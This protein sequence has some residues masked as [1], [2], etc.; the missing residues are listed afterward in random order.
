MLGRTY[1]II[2]LLVILGYAKAFPVLPM[3][4]FLPHHQEYDNFGAP[5]HHN[6]IFDELSEDFY[7]DDVDH[8]HSTTVHDPD[9]DYY[10]LGNGINSLV[11]VNPH[12]NYHN[13][14]EMGHDSMFT[15]S[16]ASHGFDSTMDFMDDV[17]HDHL[18]HNHHHQDIQHD[19]L[20]HDHYHHDIQHDHPH[21]HLQDVHHAI[22][23]YEHDVHEHLYDDQHY[24]SYH[25]DDAYNQRYDTNDHLYDEH[26]YPL[27][28]HSVHVED[29]H[30]INWFHHDVQ[31]STSGDYKEHPV[32]FKRDLVS[33]SATEATSHPIATKDDLVHKDLPKN[34]TTSSTKLALASTLIGSS[35]NP[36][37][38]KIQH[39]TSLATNI[40]PGNKQDVPVKRDY[41]HH[42]HNQKHLI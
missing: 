36:L 34:D 10:K 41:I 12:H 38:T 30:T 16:K 1:A 17:H 14:A 11:D 39:S 26:H 18:H 25:H 32:F 15:N 37:A 2:V 23:S 28:H 19:H 31:G 4:F 42:H 6:N 13:L 5:I 3:H 9:H 22:P 35:P 20:H 24:P 40:V 29:P 21:H 7:N 8:Y 27:D 33:E